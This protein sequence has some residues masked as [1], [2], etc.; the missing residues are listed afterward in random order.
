ML[1]DEGRKLSLQLLKYALVGG[2]AF[3]LDFSLLYLLTEYLHFH[4]IVSATIAFIAGLLFNYG[5]SVR[6]VFR[7][8]ALSSKLAEFLVFSLIGVIGLLLNDGLI[9]SLTEV[10]KLHYLLSKVLAA[11]VVFFWNFF[12]RRQVLFISRS[13]LSK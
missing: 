13:K 6:W 7:E 8:R 3:L 2:A 5:L 10:G 9:W 1:N 11:V 12:A 4:Y